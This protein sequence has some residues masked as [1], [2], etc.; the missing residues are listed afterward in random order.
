MAIHKVLKNIKEFGLPSET[1]HK[2]YNV[3]CLP[4][5][6]IKGS[7]KSLEKYSQIKE[8]NEEHNNPNTSN[9]LLFENLWDLTRKMK[10]LVM[11]FNI[12]LDNAYEHIIIKGKRPEDLKSLI[13]QQE[14]DY[15]LK[16]GSEMGLLEVEKTI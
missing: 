4:R 6:F 7:I 8:R 16:L 15:V 12:D 11:K 14:I 2:W 3:L 5:W 9:G 13:D 1:C 10:N